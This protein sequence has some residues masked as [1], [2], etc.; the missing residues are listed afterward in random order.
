MGIEEWRR[1]QEEDPE[2]KPVLQWFRS[3]QQP[4]WGEVE[5]QALGTKSLWSQWAGLRIHEGILQRR[6]REPATGEDGWKVLVPQ[7]FGVTKMLHRIRQKFYWS[8]CC[9]CNDCTAWK[10]P[11]NWSHA[12]LKQFPV[13]GPMERV[14]VNIL[15]P[16]PSLEKGNRFV[17]L[18]LDYFTKWPEAYTIPD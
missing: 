2:L 7:A 5:M 16:F 1:Q 17:L 9:R 11:T 12:P 14:G 15:G 3:W 6:R 4:T 10:G 13:S 18:V 8:Q